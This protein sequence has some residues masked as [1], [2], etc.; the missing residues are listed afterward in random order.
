MFHDSPLQH[1]Q[2]RDPP[3][4]QRKFSLPDTVRLRRQA[5]FDSRRPLSR[6]LPHRYLH[7]RFGL[8]SVID[9]DV[10]PGLAPCRGIPPRE[11][12]AERSA[13]GTKG[14]GRRL[15]L[16]RASQVYTH[17]ICSGKVVSADIA[18]LCRPRLLSLTTGTARFQQAKRGF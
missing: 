14:E 6:F 2:G 12:T 3:F 13:A 7:P 1:P 18:T 10:Q 8:E 4:A 17:K 16:I 11:R 5:S 15:N 9:G